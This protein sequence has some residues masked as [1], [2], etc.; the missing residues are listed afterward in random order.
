[1]PLS[2]TEIYIILHLLQTLCKGAQ[3]WSI[4]PCRNGA[5]TTWLVEVTIT[6]SELINERMNECQWLLYPCWHKSVTLTQRRI[7]QNTLLIYPQT[8]TSSQMTHSFCHHS[9]ESPLLEFLHKPFHPTPPVPA[10]DIIPTVNP[11]GQMIS[12]GWRGRTGGGGDRA[13]EQ[14]KNPRI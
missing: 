4:Y 9:T 7:P 3:A 6:S 12:Y 14:K 13:N 2:A 1:M 11:R 8:H 5:W 10:W